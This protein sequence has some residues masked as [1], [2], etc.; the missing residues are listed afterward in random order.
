MD[1]GPE[2]LS[3]REFLNYAWLASLGI[4]TVELGIVTFAFALPRLRP[5][6]FGGPVDVGPVDALPGVGAP[7]QPFNRAKFWWVVTEAGALAIYKVC[8]HLGCIYDWKPTE[9]KFT[10]PC[11]GS[12]FERDG[13]F[14]AG[15]APRSLDRFV[16]EAR[17]ASGTIVAQTGE[18]GD[19]V[20]I[21][22]GANITVQTGM[23]I[24]GAPKA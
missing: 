14:I 16:I 18:A 20:V 17:D 7:P 15:P 6:E 5:G 11:H 19:P 13:T 23:R 1:G 2:E 10:C 21:P 4:L 8:T 9:V 3:R 22:A 12:Q 24:Q